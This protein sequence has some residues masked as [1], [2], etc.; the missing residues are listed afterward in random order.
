MTKER[1]QIVDLR[2]GGPVKRER[3]LKEWSGWSE[4]DC[5]NSLSCGLIGTKLGTKQA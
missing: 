5:G 4:T 1:Q 3:E 2:S